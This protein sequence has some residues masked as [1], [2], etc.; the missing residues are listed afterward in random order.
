MYSSIVDAI[1]KLY[2]LPW[3]C[4]HIHIEL[5]PLTVLCLSPGSLAHS[6]TDHHVGLSYL[7]WLCCVCPQVP[8]LIPWLTTMIELPPLTVLCLSPG[9]LAHSLTDHLVYHWVTSPDCAVFAPRFP[10][11][12]PDWPPCGASGGQRGMLR[13]DWCSHRLSYRGKTTQCTYNMAELQVLD[14]L[15]PL[16]LTKYELWLFSVYKSINERLFEVGRKI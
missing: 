5:P 9:S 8:W 16:M 1:Y 7:P 6:L 4:S 13:S 14:E 15:S 10:G 3:L 2:C 12:F 11:S